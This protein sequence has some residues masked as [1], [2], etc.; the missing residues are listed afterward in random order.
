M[1]LSST[2]YFVRVLENHLFTVDKIGLEK[3][4]VLFL[5]VF[6]NLFTSFFFF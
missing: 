1:L 2:V 3:S 4:T 6:V 5:E